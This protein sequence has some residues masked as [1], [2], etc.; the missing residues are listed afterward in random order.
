M[1]EQIDH[2]GGSRGNTPVDFDAHCVRTGHR[3][4]AG[5]QSGD[6]ETVPLHSGPVDFRVT[7][8]GWLTVTNLTLAVLIRAAYR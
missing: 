1:A 8:G 4:A 2:T 5:F 3:G 6:R 7:P